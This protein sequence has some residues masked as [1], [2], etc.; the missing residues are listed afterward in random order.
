MKVYEKY[1]LQVVMYTICL[2]V[3]VCV[4]EAAFIIVQFKTSTPSK[5]L[6]VMFSMYLPQCITSDLNDT[7][8]PQS[9]FG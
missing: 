2:C 4:R 5:H 7:K 8:F 6:E 1:K 3:C 9:M